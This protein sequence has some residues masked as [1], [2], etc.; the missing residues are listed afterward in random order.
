MN[1]SFY[2]G[3]S[4]A[5]SGVVNKENKVIV[6]NDKFFIVLRFCYIG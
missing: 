3:F 4:S 5:N 2:D 6:S 1:G